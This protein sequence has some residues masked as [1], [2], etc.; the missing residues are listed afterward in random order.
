MIDRN[1]LESIISQSNRS[2]REFV[3]KHYSKGSHL[4]TVAVTK[5]RVVIESN[6][7][8]D[9]YGIVDEIDSQY[10]EWSPKPCNGDVDDDVV[11]DPVLDMDRNTA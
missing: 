7:D 8:D 9:E 1:A 4:Y 5:D 6:D 3:T 2:V 10:S 11:V